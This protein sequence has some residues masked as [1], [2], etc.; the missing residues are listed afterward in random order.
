LTTHQ[1]FD[2]IG[3]VQRIAVL[4]LCLTL[5]RVV[6]ADTTF[7]SA[8]GTLWNYDMTQEFGEGVHPSEAKEKIG[9]DGK[10][11]LPVSI[12]VA[13]TEK[14]DGVETIRYETHRY[15]VVS[16]IEYL[17]ITADAVTAMAR[18]G[19]DGEI[20]KLV[21]PQ[22]ILGLP[23][24]A[25]E[26]WTYQG[27]AGDIETEQ[28]SEIVGEEPVTVPAGKFKAFHLHLEQVSPTPPKV[29]EERW[30]VPDLGYVKIVTAVRRA[31]DRLLQ[32]ITLEL[33]EMPKPGERPA[34]D[35]TAAEK[36][37]LH[38]VLAKELTGE[39]ATT[40]PPGHPKI[41]ARWQGETLQKG[42]KIRGVWIAEDVGDVAPPNYKMDEV[43]LTA[44]GP[45]AFG[46]FTMT[47]PTKGWPIGKYRV[48]FYQGDQLVETLK[49]EIAK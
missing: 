36:K 24:R 49:F 39:P 48:E 46:T 20:Y 4:L 28:Q 6:A 21:P 17:T 43:T 16:L 35:G 11:H 25:G 3:P 9:A 38:A 33:R 40:F 44:D 26:K 15:S 14:I 42:D 5:A 13:G 2:S 37:P 30:F 47:K 18:A 32:R 19:E 45:R 34:V 41:F 31:D 7:P 12:F 1:R 29:A 27:Q 22:K 10:L 23:P 8:K